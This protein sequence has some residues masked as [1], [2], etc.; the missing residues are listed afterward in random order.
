VTQGQLVRVE[1]R[2]DGSNSSGDVNFAIGG[3]PISTVN[4]R[5][6]TQSNLDVALVSGVPGFS[7]SLSGNETYKYVSFEFVATTSGVLTSQTTSGS[8]SV[9]VTIQ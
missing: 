5:R 4:S 7:G 1:A 8:L 2:I 3:S 6:M 9:I